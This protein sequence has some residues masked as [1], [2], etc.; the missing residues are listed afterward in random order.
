MR[1]LTLLFLVGLATLA[2][3]SPMTSTEIDQLVQRLQ[4]T[5]S[6]QPS[7]QANFREERH[8]A[9]LKEPIVNEGKV[10]FTLPDKIRR[11]IEGKTPSTTVI[12]GRK[13]SIY[14]PNY[15]Q[16]EV[17][18]LEKRPIIK[19]SLHALT[20]GLD[21]REIKGYFD[22]QGSKDG[23]QYQITL[24]PKTAA[25]RKVIQS[26]DLTIG[27]DL[28]PEKVTV[29]NTKGEVFTSTY[30]NVRRENIPDSTFE[31]TPPPGTKVTRPLGN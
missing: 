21:F 17:Y 29:H 2:D 19:D 4:A 27:E 12:D 23:N 14:Y 5:T 7:L 16:V 18:D 22:L 10:W 9:M 25:V 28:I 13:M 6:R 1:M 26:V 24:I 3:A 11:E 20:A 31:F 15:Q 30:S 8:L